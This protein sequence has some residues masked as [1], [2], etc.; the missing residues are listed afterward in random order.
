MTVSII[1]RAL[2][3]EKRI[4]A[5]IEHA[6][7]ALPAGHGEVIL[8]DAGSHDATVAIASGYPIRVVQLVAPARANSG[9]AAQLGYQYARYEYVCLIDADMELDPDF[10]T[11][12]VEYLDGHS[13]TA[14]VTGRIEETGEERGER[15]GLPIIV[16]PL[17]IGGVGSMEGGGVYRRRAIEMVGYL[18]DRNLH[19]Y[20]DFDLGLRLRAAG[21][22]LHRL[23]RR[24]V[25]HRGRGRSRASHLLGQWHSGAMM[26]L[27]ELLR[28]ALRRGRAPALLRQLPELWLSLAAW[29]WF[30][31]ILGVL[32]LAPQGALE[33]A[34]AS[35]VAAVLMATLRS[36]SLTSGFNTVASGL[37]RAAALPFGFFARRRNPA[38]WVESRVL[39]DIKDGVAL[40]DMDDPYIEASARLSAAG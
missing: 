17:R 25:G 18:T 15:T 7:K 37:L 11:I 9:I 10:L 2:N 20:V 1:I 16:R 23:D 29:I 30:V 24:F 32:A 12:A 3:E 27:G 21:W 19:S 26:G 22:K 39:G 4:G 33:F 35:L 8:A 31:A 34:T 13:R 28:A 6:L 5:T 14:G 38:E 36:G 40:V